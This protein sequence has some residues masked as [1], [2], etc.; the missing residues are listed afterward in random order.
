M[1]WDFNDT[2]FNIEPIDDDMEKVERLGVVINGNEVE[3]IGNIFD[4]PELLEGGTE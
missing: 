3:V 4:N 2:S 1:V